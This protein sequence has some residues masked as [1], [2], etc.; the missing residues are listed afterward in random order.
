MKERYQMEKSRYSWKDDIKTDLQNR[1]SRNR[2]GGKEL[3][4]SGS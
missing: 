2:M 3:V 1:S 4:S